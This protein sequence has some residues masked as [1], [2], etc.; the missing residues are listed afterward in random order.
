MAGPFA[1]LVVADLVNDEEQID[2]VTARP[3]LIIASIGISVRDEELVAPLVEERKLPAFEKLVAVDPCTGFSRGL[4]VVWVGGSL[5]P[6]Q[7]EE[8]RKSELLRGHCECGMWMRE[9]SSGT[10]GTCEDEIPTTARS[11]I[12]ALSNR[13]KH[14]GWP[15]N[16]SALQHRM[17]F[18]V[19]VDVKK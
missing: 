10:G 5:E 6:A 16:R 11:Y 2:K 3:E 1:I 14:S 4:G 19:A 9:S 7:C 15:L 12:V 8:V 13:R 18:A 17:T